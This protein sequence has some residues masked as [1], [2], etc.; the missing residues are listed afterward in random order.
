MII[1]ITHEHDLDGLGSQAIIKRYFRLNP[2]FKSVEITCLYS[3]YIDFVEK[4]K[5]VIN[6]Y[7]TPMELLISDIGFNLEFKNLFSIFD[8]VDPNLY[9]IKWYDHHI[10]DEEIQLKLRNLLDLYENDP[11]RCTAEIVKDYYLP[12]DPIAQ[13]IAEYA[14]DTDFKT[15]NYK[16]ASEFQLIIE[17]NRGENFNHNKLKIVELLAE[18]DFDNPWFDSLFES[19][20]DWYK[21]ESKSTLKNVYFFDVEDFGIVAISYANIGGGKITELLLEKYPNLDAAI[22]IDKRYNEII[23]HS[24]KV[25]C[26]EFAKKFNGGGH[27]NRAGFK[28]PSVF[29]SQT[30][31]NQD[32][33]EEVKKNLQNS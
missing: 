33:I 22:G 14:R 31:L 29:S 7:S 16:K 23:I 3:H 27:E 17:F 32:F 11:K 1:S 13:K 6:N 2:Q 19:L 4:V 30:E 8:N 15:H 5:N 9:T 26:R 24:E 12:E 10:V 21:N 28:F 18:G 20:K 25:N